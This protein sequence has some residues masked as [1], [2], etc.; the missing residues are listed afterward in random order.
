MQWQTKKSRLKKEITQQQIDFANRLRNLRLT[1][2]LSLQEV[3]ERIGISKVTLSRYETLD[4]V[5][6]PSDKIELLAKVYHV[7]PAYLMGWE[8]NSI[9]LTTST[10]ICTLK[11][12][13]DEKILMLKYRKLT[14]EGKETVDT[15]LNL[16]YKAACPKS[17]L[18]PPT[19][20]VG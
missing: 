5:N 4:I 13:P 15:I 20:E 16:Q 17:Q 18:D 12:S 2:K 19:D 10:E 14:P 7:S 9:P 8:S 1:Q 6:I 11:C 3:S